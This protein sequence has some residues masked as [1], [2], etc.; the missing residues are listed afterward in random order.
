[1]LDLGVG[2][3]LKL[4]VGVGFCYTLGYYTIRV[5]VQVRIQVRVRVR[6]RILLHAG[7]LRRALGSVHQ[8]GPK[9][10]TCV[11]LGSHTHLL[12]RNI[13]NVRNIVKHYGI[14]SATSMDG[15]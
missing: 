3:R 15:G 11:E 9:L 6:V 13:R 5:K 14:T 2:L 12:K 4:R 1:M 10:G 7:L 8:L